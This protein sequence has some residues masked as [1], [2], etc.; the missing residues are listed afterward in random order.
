MVVIT[1]LV[2]GADYRRGLKECL[3]SKAEYAKKHG[4]A[5]PAVNVTGS[6]TVN[7]VMESAAKL[8]SPVIIQF[9]NEYS[10]SNDF[11]IIPALN[12]TLIS[13]K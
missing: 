5:L 13:S 4:Y 2:I 11:I 10:T 8:N 9:S 7:S 6:S 12:S 3:D 1:T